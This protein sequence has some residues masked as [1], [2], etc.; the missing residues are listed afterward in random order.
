M[1]ELTSPTDRLSRVQ[2]KM[3]EWMANGARLGWILD[4][5]NREVYICRPGGIEILKSPDRLK[6]EGPV[7]GFVLELAGIWEPGW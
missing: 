6:G 5:D 3:R 2:E 4:P 7:D 1:V